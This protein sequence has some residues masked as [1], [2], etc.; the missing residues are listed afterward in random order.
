VSPEERLVVKKIT[1]CLIIKKEWDEI[2]SIG[3]VKLNVI[4]NKLSPKK[5]KNIQKTN[6]IYDVVR[7]VITVN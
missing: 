7:D 5:K 3:V 6:N 2:V 1:C 4:N